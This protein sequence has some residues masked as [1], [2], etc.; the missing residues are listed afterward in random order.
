V[1]FPELVRENQWGNKIMLKWLLYQKM[2]RGK[3]L[4]LYFLKKMKVRILIFVGEIMV[5]LRDNSKEFPMHNL[6]HKEPLLVKAGMYLSR[7]HISTKERNDLEMIN[8]MQYYVRLLLYFFRKN[9][10]FLFELLM[11]SELFLG[12]LSRYL[13]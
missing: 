11:D 13:W 7:M 10:K 9:E 3:Y 12:L 6:V 8:R 4:A 5:F 1:S 2:H